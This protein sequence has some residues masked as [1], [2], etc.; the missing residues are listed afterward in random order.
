[1]R[2]NTRRSHSAHLLPRAGTLEAYQ[3]ELTAKLS[4]PRTSMGSGPSFVQGSAGDRAPYPKSGWPLMESP[5]A[6][7]L[8]QYQRRWTSGSVRLVES[9]A[10]ES[11]LRADDGGPLPDIELGGATRSRFVLAARASTKLR[12]YETVTD[13]ENSPKNTGLAHSDLRGVA[14]HYRPRLCSI[15]RTSRL[16]ARF[17]HGG[18]GSSAS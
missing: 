18:S 6:S 17:S 9:G 10:L 3:T 14:G 11:K 2:C 13:Q 5:K 12:L 1:M 16:R 7:L 15:H 4:K 8:Q